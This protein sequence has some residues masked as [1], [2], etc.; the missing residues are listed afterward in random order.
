VADEL[1]F[2]VFVTPLA[3]A[4]EHVLELAEVAEVSGLDHV[5]VQDHPYQKDYL[6]TWTLLTTIAARTSTIRVAPNV[7]SLPLRPPVVLAKSAASLDV[8]SH[9]RVELGLGAGAFWDAIVAAG[10]PRRTPGEAVDAVVEAIELMRQFWGGQTV[11]FTGEHYQAIGLRPGPVPTRPIP[12]WLG[13]YKPRMLRVTGRLADAWIPS[14]GYAEPGALR[15]MNDVI[16]AAA[17]KAGRSPASI[18]RLLN[19]SGTF[20]G[21]QGFLAGPA[22]LWA[23]RL[24]ALVVEQGMTGFVLA[25]DDADMVTTFATQVAPLAREMVRAAETSAVTAGEGPGAAGA[26]AASAPASGGSA[27]GTA[28]GAALAQPRV[29]SVQPRDDTARRGISVRPTP[30][31]G[32]RLSSERLWREDDRPRWTGEPLPSY[33]RAQEAQPQHLID[34]HDML[35][36][37]LAQVRDIV[38]QVVDGHL[39]VGQARSVINTMTMRQ[40]NWAMGAY[41]QSY[42]RI[43]A[44]HHTLEDHSVF[45]HLR[46]ADPLVAPVLDRLEHEHLVSAGVLERVDAALV[47]LVDAN[48]YGEL[49]EEGLAALSHEVDLLTDTLLSHLAYEERELLHPLAQHGLN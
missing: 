25:A 23:E 24:T 22:E 12:I 43:V 27:R 32:E 30:D 46:R 47:A 13:A 40:N 19:V 17:L 26:G 4:A 31:D 44:S 49:G 5:S 8:L 16:D 38:A 6:D 20:S 42:C 1:E 2:G 35:R 28:P 36:S 48:P 14:L 3:A 45:R 15:G 33:T 9:G 41:C 34:V 39:T 10:G 21:G 18:R 7:A 37:E 11:R 29:A